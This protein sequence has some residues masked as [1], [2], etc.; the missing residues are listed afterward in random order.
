MTEA[1]HGAAHTKN[2]YLSAQYRRVAA[3]RGRKRAIVAVGHSILTISYYLLTR[4][5]KYQDL[6]ANYCDERD[7]EGVKCRAVRRLEQLGFQ[8]TLAPPTQVLP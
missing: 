6:G 5:T 7:R 8:V 4:P 1:A 2:K 3:R